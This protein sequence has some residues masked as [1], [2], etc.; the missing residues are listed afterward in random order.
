MYK[1]V[2]PLKTLSA[3]MVQDVGGKAANLGELISIG[4][5]V[6]PGFCVKGV[7]YPF[8]LESNRL[9]SQVSE[10]AKGIDFSKP[11]DIEQKTIQIR[12]LITHAN[13]PQDLEEEIFQNCEA[14]K[15]A[16]GEEPLVAVRSSVA[17]RDSAI[18]S[19]P[20]LMDTYHYIR[21]Y[22]HIV[23]KIKE[24]IASVWT[25]RAAFIRHHKK[26]DHSLALIAPI[27]QLMIDSETAGVMFT[28]NP[29]TSSASEILINSCCGLGE[30][31]VSGEGA[32]DIYVLNKADV[33]TKA[34]TIT[35]K[36]HMV[37]F[38]EKEGWGTKK[39]QVPPEKID[40]PTLT[41]E[42]L[43]E[44]GMIG[45]RIEN[46]YGMP[47]DIEWAF[48]RGELYILQTRKARV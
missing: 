23:Q 18:S 25:A 4:C 15:D 31:V 35:N 36:S 2:V 44:L 19:F 45:L 1:Y 39:A 16:I 24:C 10:I 9:T 20:G 13:M 14:L 41:D 38:D 17:I 37:V 46:H 3:E 5:N 28:V 32:A 29:M 47:Q 30:M 7:V 43:K 33:S 48:C 11:I 6:P 21:G 27:V 22:E 40:K 12:S 34:R 42:M 8:L 26:I